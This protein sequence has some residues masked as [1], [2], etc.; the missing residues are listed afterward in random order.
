MEWEVE[1]PAALA[2]VHTSEEADPDLPDRNT[3]RAK[4]IEDR[5]GG[6]TDPSGVDLGSVVQGEL[7]VRSSVVE[8]P[9]GE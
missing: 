5:H 8:G 3:K 4:K 2:E 6:G 9:I 7:S 1:R